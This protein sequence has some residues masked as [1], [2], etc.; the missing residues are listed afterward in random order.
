MIRLAVGI[1]YKVYL[2]ED[3]Y[4]V[5]TIMSRSRQLTDRLDRSRGGSARVTSRTPEAC[6]VLSDVWHLE[7]ARA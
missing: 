3:T 4:A 1:F 2:M 5:R 6:R 7:R